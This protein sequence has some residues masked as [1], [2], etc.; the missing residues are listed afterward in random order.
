MNLNE[1]NIL[2]FQRLV[3][4]YRVPVFRELYRRYGIITCHSREKKG[5]VKKSYV[6]EMDFPNES[7]TRVYFGLNKTL[8][9]QNI[10]PVLLRYRPVIVISQFSLGYFTFWFLLALKPFFGYKLV[11]WTHGVRNNE[12]HNPFK[13]RSRKIVLRFIRNSDA[14]IFYSNSRKEIVSK[15]LL[16]NNHLFVAS[17]TLDTATFKNIYTQLSDIGKENVK[18]EIGFNSKFNLIFTGRLLSE[19]RIDL[20]LD[21]FLLLNTKY[22]INLHF[23]GDGPEKAL[24]MKYSEKVN[25]IKYHGAIYDDIIVGKFL[26]ASDIYLMP[27]YIGLGI[28]HAFAF[29]LPVISC[30]TT[31]NG[32]FHSPEVE[33]FIDDV[34]GLWC[35][36][37]AISLVTKV[38]TMLNNRDLIK[39]MSKNAI[40]TAYNQ[41]T[42]DKMILGFACAI[43]YLS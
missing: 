22:D 8:I 7:I 21:A 3:P 20:I 41:C 5:D 27:G 39:K 18:N 15:K 37:D 38:E 2:L 25:G 13:S 29:G 28:V 24:I 40:D 32:P 16:K 9:L 30:R 36:S 19:K 4:A 42:L 12:L 23:I 11:L 1:G 10:F 31:Q 6:K 17:N 35:D 26:F 34:N 14:V 33:Y 43:R